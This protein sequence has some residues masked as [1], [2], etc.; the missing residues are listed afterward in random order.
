MRFEAAAAGLKTQALRRSNQAGGMYS[1]M[2]HSAAR[3]RAGHARFDPRQWLEQLG[4]GS[5]TTAA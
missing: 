3:Q 1:Q 5:L 4:F 2:R